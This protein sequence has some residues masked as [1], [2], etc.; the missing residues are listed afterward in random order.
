[1]FAV[2]GYAALPFVFRAAPALAS[3]S[4]AYA[5]V[6]LRPIPS[7]PLFMCAS[8]GPPSDSVF[9]RSFFAPCARRCP[10]PHP[11]RCPPTPRAQNFAP[12]LFTGDNA[13]LPVVS[14]WNGG[15]IRAN[16]PAGVGE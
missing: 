5:V 7:C 9:T 4:R 12:S 3:A 16:I 11:L 1:M 13:G 8:V 14:L 6:A 2:I 10:P 15:G